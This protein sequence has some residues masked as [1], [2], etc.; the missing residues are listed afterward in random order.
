MGESFLGSRGSALLDIITLAQPFVLAGLF[1]ARGLARR[2][3]YQAHRNLLSILASVLTVLLI[4]FETDL[5][6]NGGVW[7]M[8]AGS[9]FSGTAFLDILIAVHLTLAFVTAILWIPLLPISL[10]RFGASPRPGAFSAIHRRWGWAAL[11]SLTGTAVTGM[12]MY[13]FGMVL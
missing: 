3:R 4:L 8:T 7:S 12:A 11:L 13:L 2:G 9:R 1:Y 5:R 10:W 6:A